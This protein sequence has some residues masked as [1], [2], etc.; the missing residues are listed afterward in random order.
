LKL[1]GQ[2]CGII[3]NV[4]IFRSEN[5]LQY[6]SI[7]LLAMLLCSQSFGQIEDL[8]LPISLDADSTDYDGKSSMLMFRGLRLTQGRIGVEADEG[9]ASKL[10]FEDSVWHFAGNVVIDTENGH[11]E[12]A[13][14]D[15]QFAGHQLRLATITGSPASFEMRRPGSDKVT[16]AEAGRLEYDFDAGVVEFSEQATIT[17]GGN[18]ISS[19]YLVYNIN[20]QRINAQSGGDGDPKV[21]ITYTPATTPAPGEENQDESGTPEVPNTVDDV[22]DESDGVVPESSG[23]FFR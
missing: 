2:I 17:E 18:Q 16:Y 13:T 8:R 5:A 9:R 15:L 11:I 21:R 1:A 22:P 6:S 19:N 4:H 14:A 23:D 20:E 10:D 3:S 7:A 12:S